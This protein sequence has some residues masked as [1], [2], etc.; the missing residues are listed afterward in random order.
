M[1]E[2]ARYQP[3]LHVRITGNDRPARLPLTL[4]APAFLRGDRLLLNG[5]LITWSTE[6]RVRGRTGVP[7]FAVSRAKMP[8]ANSTPRAKRAGKPRT[9]RSFIRRNIKS[10]FSAG[11]ISSLHWHDCN[12]G[13]R[14]LIQIDEKSALYE[15]SRGFSRIPRFDL[16]AT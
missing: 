10:T 11:D 3:V 14:L 5:H 2:C 4:R 16:A 12:F 7:P 13:T 1:Y 6:D 9:A 15:I 8:R